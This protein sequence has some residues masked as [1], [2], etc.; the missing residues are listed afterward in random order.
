MPVV[1]SRLNLEDFLLKGVLMTDH[2]KEAFHIIEEHVVFFSVLAALLIIQADLLTGENIEFPILFT[3][4]VALAAW[5][6]KYYLAYG[7][8]IALPLLRVG[9]VLFVWERSHDIHI[10]V[11]NAI[12]TAISLIGYTYLITK[13]TL[14][15]RNLEAK[16][17]I[18]EE[19]ISGM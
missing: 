19:K 10:L 8:S 3:I 1:V 18:L 9:F 2:T 7:F 12:I 16:V 15:K 14:K 13:I 11:I 6:F 17:K 4:P 5:G